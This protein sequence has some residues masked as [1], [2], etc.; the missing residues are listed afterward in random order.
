[1][2]DTGPEPD[3]AGFGSVVGGTALQLRFFFFGPLTCFAGWAEM[4][5][6]GINGLG[7]LG[8]LGGSLRRQGGV[9]V[10]RVSG[11]PPLSWDK[12]PYT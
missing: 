8:E 6:C 11:S 1:M 7:D 5:V 9:T 2:G 4:A 10:A 12:A 3:T